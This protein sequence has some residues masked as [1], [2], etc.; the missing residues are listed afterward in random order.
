M[1][2]TT[3]PSES[4]FAYSAML[5]YCERYSASGSAMAAPPNAPASVPTSV[6][7]T[8][9]VAR[10]RS[11]LSASSSAR[12]AVWSPASARCCSR[13]LRAE[14][15][16]ISLMANTPFATSSSRTTRTSVPIPIPSSVSSASY[17]G[18]TAACMCGRAPPLRSGSGC[19]RRRARY[20]CAQRRRA[21]GA[22]R[23]RRVPAVPVH[24]RRVLSNRD[25][26]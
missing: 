18:G 19:A 17:N 15:R 14:T 3:R 10:K 22:H 21:P 7:P 4:G 25:D 13:D 16:A 23:P 1:P 5:G 8:C 24:A 2:S 26:P 9:T 12:R 11:G 20:D 6:M